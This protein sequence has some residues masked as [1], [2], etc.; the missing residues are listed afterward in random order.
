MGV[1][2]RCFMADGDGIVKISMVR[3]IEKMMLD[4]DVDDR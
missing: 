3:E 2:R 4:Q 1:S